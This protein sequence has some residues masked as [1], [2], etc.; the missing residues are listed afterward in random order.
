MEETAKAQETAQDVHGTD[1]LAQLAAKYGVEEDF[2]R[3]LY[4]NITDKENFARA[5]RM[6]R[7]GT[8][9]YETATSGK[10]ICIADIRKEVAENYRK[11]RA[12]IRQRMEEYRKIKEYY[13][14]CAKITTRRKGGII[15]A[16]FIR[17]G[18]LVAFGHWTPKDGGIY[19][20]D[21]EVM[22]NH[23]WKPKDILR[24]IRKAD[25]QFYKAIKRTAHAEDPELFRFDERTVRKTEGR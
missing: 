14:G 6:F 17:D 11:L 8:L 12:T 18:R 19:A 2:A 10:P 9:K 25:R 20:A 3:Q 23:N 13:D 21:N 16:A 7:D 4:E 5:L 1:T 22:P 24:G 15:D